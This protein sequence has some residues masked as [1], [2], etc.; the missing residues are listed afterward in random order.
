MAKRI[1]EGDSLATFGT[2]RSYTVGESAQMPKH[3]HV[4]QY[5]GEQL[6]PMTPAQAREL[7]INLILAADTIE[8]G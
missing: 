6:S 7:A 5:G 8:K 1:R 2:V 3:I 4:T